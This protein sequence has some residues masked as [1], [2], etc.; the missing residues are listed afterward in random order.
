MIGVK[1]CVRISERVLFK[2]SRSVLNTDSALVR[3]VGL[4]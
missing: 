2:G 4:T 3:I 1:K